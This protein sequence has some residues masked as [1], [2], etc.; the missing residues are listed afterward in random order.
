MD[1]TRVCWVQLRCKLN[2]N[3]LVEWC[4]FNLLCVGSQMK[5]ANSFTWATVFS[6]IFI[7]FYMKLRLTIIVKI[8]IRE[9]REPLLLQKVKILK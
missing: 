1:S 3:V 2:P 8:E 5:R 9:E 6:S 7:D 4:V